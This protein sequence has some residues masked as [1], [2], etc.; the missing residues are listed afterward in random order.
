MDISS[1]LLL[2]LHPPSEGEE[3]LLNKLSQL[4]LLLSDT[5]KHYLIRNLVIKETSGSEGNSK[6]LNLIRCSNSL[7]VRGFQGVY[8]YTISKSMTP[9]DQMSDLEL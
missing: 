4:I 5:S 7:V 3:I 9:R 2:L 6:G 1:I 8:P